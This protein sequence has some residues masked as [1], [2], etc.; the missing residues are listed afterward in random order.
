MRFPRHFSGGIIVIWIIAGVQ[1]YLS[2]K[3]IQKKTFHI[4]H[5]EFCLV[6]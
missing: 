3:F 4:I 2:P 6:K 1:L 5:T